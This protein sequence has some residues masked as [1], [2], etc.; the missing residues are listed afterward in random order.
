V[1]VTLD[2]SGGTV[3]LEVADDGRGFDLGPA[4]AAGRLGLASMRDRAR[5]AGGR[6]ELRS[7]PGAGTTVRLLLPVGG[8]DG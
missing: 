6:L 5:A 7:S 4:G 2:A 3:R 1:E 8:C